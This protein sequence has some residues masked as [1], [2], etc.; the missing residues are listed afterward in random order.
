MP[1]ARML[2]EIKLKEMKVKNQ[3]APPL[4]YGLGRNIRVKKFLLSAGWQEVCAT[5]DELMERYIA[6]MSFGESNKDAIEYARELFNY[7]KSNL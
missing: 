4:I 3:Q 7:K 6:V 1:A 5:S 2:A